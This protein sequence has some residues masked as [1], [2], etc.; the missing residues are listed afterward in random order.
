MADRSPAVTTLLE[1]GA[2]PVGPERVVDQALAAVP[3]GCFDDAVA[4]DAPREQIADVGALVHAVDK[5]GVHTTVPVPMVPYVGP[6]HAPTG[7]EAATVT[8]PRPWWPGS[9]TVLGCN[10]AIPAHG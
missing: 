4:I 5:H 8:P 3:A 6:G 10:D 9:V 1:A 2:E 7:R